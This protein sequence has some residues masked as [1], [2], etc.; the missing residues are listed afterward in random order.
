MIDLPG[1]GKKDF[2]SKTLAFLHRA[3]VGRF[4]RGIGFYSAWK[5]FERD[6][7]IV[8][9]RIETIKGKYTSHG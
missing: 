5:S 3:C 6:K 8:I 9:Q 4:A 1:Y 7:P 2:G